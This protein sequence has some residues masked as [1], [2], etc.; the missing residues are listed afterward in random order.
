M[1]AEKERLDQV[2]AKLVALGYEDVKFFF[3]HTEN[4]TL[5]QVATEAADV[6]EAVL[7]KRYSDFKPF[8]ESV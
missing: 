3:G 5:S 8:E 7:K 2:Q 4:K 6:L 1:S